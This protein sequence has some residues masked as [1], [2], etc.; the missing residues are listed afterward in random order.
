MA[1][2]LPLLEEQYQP[3]GLVSNRVRIVGTTIGET[4]SRVDVALWMVL[5]VVAKQSFLQNPK[6]VS[7]RGS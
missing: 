7:R 6:G 2:E 5:S 1:M 4:V 3:T